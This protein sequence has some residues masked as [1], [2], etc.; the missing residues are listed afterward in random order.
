MTLPLVLDG[1]ANLMG[2]AA[3]VGGDPGVYQG[4]GG[5]AG[6]AKALSRVPDSVEEDFTCV[7]FPP[8]QPFRIEYDTSSG[9]RVMRYEIPVR[10]FIRP[11]Q[12]STSPQIVNEAVPFVDAM[13]A[14]VE[15]RTKLGTIVSGIAVPSSGQIGPFDF[16]G[17]RWLVVEIMVSAVEKIPVSLAA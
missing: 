1:L 10:V 3:V 5:V 7:V 6:V 12:E 17:G 9:F 15:G 13:I 14:A 2:G 4:V 16:S 8:E 11:I